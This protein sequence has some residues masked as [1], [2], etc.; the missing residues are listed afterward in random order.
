VNTD[1]STSSELFT[2]WKTFY[3]STKSFLSSTSAQFSKAL[4][5]QAAT[6]V[7]KIITMTVLVLLGLV[8]LDRFVLRKVVRMKM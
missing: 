4:T 6:P 3:S 1:D 8:A 5:A 7:S 2:A